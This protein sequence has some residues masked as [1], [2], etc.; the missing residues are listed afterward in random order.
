MDERGPKDKKIELHFDGPVPKPV[1]IM[2]DGQSLGD[3]G[4]PHVQYEIANLQHVPGDRP[5]EHSP[6]M[7]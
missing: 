5:P 1:H 3:I 2:A 6:E 4:E 7:S